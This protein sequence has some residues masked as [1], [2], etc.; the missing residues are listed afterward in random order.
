[1]R[2]VGQYKGCDIRMTGLQMSETYGGFL[3]GP[4]EKTFETVNWEMINVGIPRRVEKM[5]GKDRALHVMEIDYKKRLPSVEVIVCL[6][7]AAGTNEGDYSDL[8]LAWF[9]E[10]DEDPFAKV[11]S[12]LKNIEWEKRAHGWMIANL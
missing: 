2:I 7:C 1:M 12:N 8:I 4:T 9:Q 11:I 3:L 6:E 10:S 5:W